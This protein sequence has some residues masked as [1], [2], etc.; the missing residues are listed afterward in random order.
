MKKNLDV[1][2]TTQPPAAKSSSPSSPKQASPHSPIPNLSKEP[3]PKQIPADYILLPD[4]VNYGML[5]LVGSGTFGCV[6]QPPVSE[7]SQV[8]KVIVPYVQPAN[9]DIS[10]IYKDGEKDFITELAIL[11]N[12]DTI[13]PDAIFTTKFK[14][15]LQISG[16]AFENNESVQKCLRKFKN[17][18]NKTF[19]QIMLENGGTT[20]DTYETPITYVKFLQLFEKFLQGM[21]VFQD[22][23]KVHL[24]IK[25]PNVLINQDK[26]SLIDF[27]ITSD[28]SEIYKYEN[29]QLLH[30][31]YPYY[32]PEFYVAAIVLLYTHSHAS[33]ANALQYILKNVYKHMENDKYFEK[34]YMREKA[35]RYKKGVKKFLKTVKELSSTKKS[36][37]DIFDTEMALKADVFP[38]YYIITALSKN[39]VYSNQKQRKFIETL[40]KKCSEPNPYD[41]ISMRELYNEVLAEY[42]TYV[43]L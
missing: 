29:Y 15:A 42:K 7:A 12:I 6:L 4:G 20:V 35:E 5:K 10:K 28:V 14:G 30:Y 8:K 17:L 39:I 19:Y 24:D 33:D 25:P 22:K 9:D 36:V 40:C 2:C 18:N 3:S 11:K 1:K 21:L 43:R 27:S 38:L 37:T 13:D 32:P 31:T 16:K 41:R 23:Q 26:I 34:D